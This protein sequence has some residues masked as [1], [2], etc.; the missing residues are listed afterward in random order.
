MLEL[1][2]PPVS[3]ATLSS[4]SLDVFF[5]PKSVAIIG[6]SDRAGSPGQALTANLFARAGQGMEVFAVNPVHKQIAGHAAYA[7]ITDVPATIDLAIIVTHAR[8]VPDIVSECIAAGVRAAI[9]ISAGF[10][11]AG[12]EGKAL[13]REIAERIRGTQLRIIGP[14][15]IGVMNPI[16]G[17]NATFARKSALPGS[18]AFISQ[19]GALCTAI[20]DW[21]LQEVLGFSA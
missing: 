11:E 14:N 13:E 4:Q 19:S 15:C 16:A 9:I 2:S 7:T 6:A 3:V 20:L 8:T 21:S 10:R 17:M 18:V 1:E 5:H 12:A